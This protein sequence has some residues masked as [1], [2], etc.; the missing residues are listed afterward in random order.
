MEKRLERIVTLR[1]TVRLFSTTLALALAPISPR[2]LS[3]PNPFFLSSYIRR[4]ITPAIPA[5]GSSS[6]TSEVPLPWVY[7]RTR[8]PAT[9]SS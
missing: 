6:M 7:A 2:R 5:L 9:D 4:W 8:S 1:L 3:S